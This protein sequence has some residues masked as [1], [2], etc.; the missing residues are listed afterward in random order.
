[1]RTIFADTFYF[2][3]V[4]SRDDAAHSQAVQL[5]ITLRGVRFLTTAW[6][7]TEY[8]DATCSRRRR[9]QGAAFLR[10]LQVQPDVAV[11]PPTPDLFEAGLALYESRPDKDW[12]LTDC[13]SF[14]VMER[15][16]VAE[17]LTGDRHF[18]QAGF[19]PLFD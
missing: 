19:R 11:V 6:V 18:A 10:H 1:M 3:A 9:A 15:E 17:A 2:L 7:L 8:A 14:V 12:S 13:V 4:S 5:S 16:G